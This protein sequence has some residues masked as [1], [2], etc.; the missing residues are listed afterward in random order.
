M[1]YYLGDT[2]DGATLVG[3]NLKDGELTCTSPI[4][5]REVG[6]VGIGQS[7]NYDT[8]NDA[9][10]IS[11]IGQSI[12]NDINPKWLAS[13]IWIRAVFWSQHHGSQHQNTSPYAQGCDL[14]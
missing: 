7:L 10:I 14:A 6:F 5:V 2:S 9:L 12:I 11:G 8:V 1:Y 3:L 4:A 13:N